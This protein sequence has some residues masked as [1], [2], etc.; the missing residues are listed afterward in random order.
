VPV[1]ALG[2]VIAQELNAD[3]QARYLATGRTSATL[4]PS[5]SG[6]GVALASSLEVGAYQ[7]GA[8]YDFI[9]DENQEIT[10]L[11]GDAVQVISGVVNQSINT[12]WV[13]RERF[14]EDS[15]RT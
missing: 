4:I 3:I 7:A 8:T 11:P 1:V 12:S 6:T 13:W 5:S 15:E 9:W 14:L 2:A 10:V